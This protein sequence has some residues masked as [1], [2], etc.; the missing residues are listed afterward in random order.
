[1]LAQHAEGEADWIAA[2]ESVERMSELSWSPGHW[3]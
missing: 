2:R 3:S 1:M